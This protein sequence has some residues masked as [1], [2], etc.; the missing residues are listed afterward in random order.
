MLYINAYI[1]V[2][3]FRKETLFETSGIFIDAFIT[4]AESPEFSAL[5]EHIEKPVYGIVARGTTT[6]ATKGTQASIDIVPDMKQRIYGGDPVT[7]AAVL[8]NG[9]SRLY[10]TPSFILIPMFYS[11]KSL[12]G[13][14]T[15]QKALSCFR[16][17]GGLLY[18]KQNT[19]G[20]VDVTVME[21]PVSILEGKKARV[22]DSRIASDLDITNAF[23]KAKNTIK[24]KRLYTSKSEFWKDAFVETTQQ[25]STNG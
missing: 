5:L 8:E 15:P 23:W 18:T 12:G 24:V 1:P 13:N 11:K 16:T 2:P 21:D 7:K 10:L 20:F 3:S 25:D 19:T 6:I 22:S 4:S 14:I 9:A 17:Y